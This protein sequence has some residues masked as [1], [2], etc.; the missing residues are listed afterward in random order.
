MSASIYDYTDK[1]VP[2]AGY[3]AIVYGVINLVTGALAVLQ[4]FS[5]HR[6]GG[7]GITDH[8][9]ASQQY[10]QHAPLFAAIA[11]FFSVVIAAVSGVLAFFIFRRSRFAIVA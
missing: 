9:F 4:S 5:Y 8:E 6:P 1:S 7:G 3:A 10:L 11:V 2:H